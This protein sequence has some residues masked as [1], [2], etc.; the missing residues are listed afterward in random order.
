MLPTIKN[1]IIFISIIVILILIYIFFV[2]KEEV[3][4]NLVS[5]GTNTL[6]VLNTNPVTANNAPDKDFLPLLLSVKNI[7][8]DDSIFTNPAFL[9]LID[10]SIVLTPS[11]DEGRPNPF[12]PLGTDTSSTKNTTP[13]SSP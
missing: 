5:T 7:K 8:L 6:N 1:S 4:N 12:A 2:K 11:G 13:K 10:S 9:S 3:A